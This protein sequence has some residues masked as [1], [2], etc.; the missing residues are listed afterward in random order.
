MSAKISIEEIQTIVSSK[1]GKLLTTEYINNHQKLDIICDVGHLCHP[2]LKTLKRGGWCGECYKLTENRRKVKHRP[3]KLEEAIKIAKEK[4]GECLSTEYINN[5]SSLKFKCGQGHEWETNLKVIKKDAWC[6]YCSKYSWTSDKISDAIKFAKELAIFRNG[7][8]L[9]NINDVSKMTDHFTWQCNAGHVWE[10]NYYNVT[11]NNSWCP[12]CSS[13]FSEKIC[14]KYIEYVLGVKFIKTRPAWLLSPLNKPMEL[15]GYNKILNV[16]FE[17]NGMQHYEVTYFSKNRLDK[18]IEYDELKIKLCEQHGVK[19]IIIPALFYKTKIDELPAVIEGELIRLNIFYDKSKLVSPHNIIDTNLI[20]AINIDR[21]EIFARI[22]NIAKDR[23]GECLSAEY[24]NSWTKLKFKCGICFYVWETTSTAIKKTWCPKCAHKRLSIDDAHE[25]AKVKNG[26]CLS[27]NYIDS[28]TKM[29]WECEFEHKWQAS[30]NQIQSGG[31][32]PEC[33]KKNRNKSRIYKIDVYKEVAIKNGGK[34]LS[35]TVNSCYD[36][37]LWECALGHT[38]MARA[39]MIK[40]AGRWCPECAMVSRINGLK[41]AHV[42]RC[43]IKP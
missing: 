9:T 4:G 30:Y 29:L 14:K 10:A 1:G 15:D 2:S 24:K 22:C 16:A 27:E 28:V 5:R 17:H 26:K 38:W 12:Q 41:K 18:I 7:L 13:F 33:F 35:E 8:C 34:C 32:C 36:K 21:E 25:L 42:K 23:G 20:K 6:P 43:K 37:L 31:W 40:N 3:E 39:D 11:S 19:L